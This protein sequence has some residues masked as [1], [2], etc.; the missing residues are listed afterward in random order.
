MIQFFSSS[1]IAR[2]TILPM[3][4]TVVA[5]P[6]GPARALQVFKAALTSKTA[7]DA[8]TSASD[9]AGF[10]VKKGGSSMRISLTRR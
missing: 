6:S 9:H 2:V 3:E 10:E 5:S 4:P 7:P 1:D 8:S